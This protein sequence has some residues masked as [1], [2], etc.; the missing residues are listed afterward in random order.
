[1]GTHLISCWLLGLKPLHDFGWWCS[2]PR[3]IP[4]T[5][6]SST[7]QTA[8]KAM[9][10]G[11]HAGHLLLTFMRYI[12]RPTRKHR[13]FQNIKCANRTLSTSGHGGHFLDITEDTSAT[14]FQHCYQSTNHNLREHFSRRTNTHFTLVKLQDILT[15]HA[16]FSTHHLLQ[17]WHCQRRHSSHCTA[18]HI[19]GFGVVGVSS[20]GSHTHSTFLRG[21]EQDILHC[22][23]PP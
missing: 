19:D 3:E 11:A 9:F 23:T 5:N 20:Y 13:T 22:D 16:P 2:S 14:D 12:Y 6:C 18:V 4:V 21:Q 15:N 7:N 1:M 8:L 10:F 17:K